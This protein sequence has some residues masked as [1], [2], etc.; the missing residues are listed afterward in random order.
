MIHLGVTAT[1]KLSA[2]STPRLVISAR[3]KPLL[4]AKAPKIH[5]PKPRVDHPELFFD[6][7]AGPT[8]E[9]KWHR[10]IMCAVLCELL[11]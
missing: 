7:N 10:H 1:E 2:T 9:R 4:R 11:R 3:G 5:P 6:V 8:A